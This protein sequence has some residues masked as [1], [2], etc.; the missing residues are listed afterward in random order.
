MHLHPLNPLHMPAIDPF[1]DDVFQGFPSAHAPPVLTASGSLVSAAADP[2]E[3][4]AR[5]LE[6]FANAFGA[7]A[8]AQVDAVLTQLA[9]ILT[10]YTHHV[11][12]VRIVI[13]GP[14]GSGKTRL[15]RTITSVLRIPGLIVPATDFCETGWKGAQVGDI[16]R[17]L[18]P[19]LFTSESGSRKV[20]VPKQ[21]VALPAVLMLDEIDKLALTHESGR[22]DGTAVAA[23]VGKQGTILP[24][25]DPL[26]ELLVQSDDAS[27]P[28]RWS[29]RS[30][31]ILCCGAF[32]QLPQNRRHTAA[33]LRAVGFS[34]ELVERMGPVLTLPSPSAATRAMLA[35]GAVHDVEVFAASLG[36]RIEGIDRF[37]QSLEAPDSSPHYVGV[38]GLTAFV[39]QRM[40]AAVAEGIAQQ[41][42]V[43][44]L[45]DVTDDA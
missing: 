39:R 3:T 20:T 23:R 7:N 44:D 8:G 4:L 43:I 37:V 28:F 5:I 13:T 16:C 38:R 32:M 24:L 26:S 35:R 12:P 9:L 18:H 27:L 30:A 34:S 6:E 22:F 41:R 17:L 11:T 42:S 40:L 2:R 21:L 29:L 19:E 15:L 31:V 14:T 1:D 45:R 36:V 25:L 33:D 10:M